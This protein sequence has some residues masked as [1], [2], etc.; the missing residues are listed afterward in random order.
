MA[1]NTMKPD[2]TVINKLAV[3]IASLKVQLSKSEK[4]DEIERICKEIFDLENEILIERGK[5]LKS[6]FARKDDVLHQITV[7]EAKLDEVNCDI[8]ARLNRYRDSATNRISRLES[9]VNSKK[10]EL[11]PPTIE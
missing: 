5:E 2:F 9:E 4:M 3:S 11:D 7:L 8:N 6:L 1:D 10:S